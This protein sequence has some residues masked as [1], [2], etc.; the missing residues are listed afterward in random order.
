MQFCKK[1]LGMK[2]TTQND[3]VYG[4]L[5]RI[6]CQSRLYLA[7]DKYWFKVLSARENKY[8]KL[9]YNLLLQDIEL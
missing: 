2:K 8:V 1:L 9:V 4:E 7:V 6:S 5:D 3:F